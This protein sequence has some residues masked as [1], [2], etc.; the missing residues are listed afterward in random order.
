VQNANAYDKGLSEIARGFIHQASAD[1]VRR[2][3]LTV[4][5]TRSQYLDGVI[6]A[7]LVDPTSW[8]L[9]QHFL[10]LPGRQ[11]A[12][13]ALV[14]DYRSNVDRY[15]Q[16]QGWLREHRPQTLVLWA[17]T[18]R[19]S[20]PGAW[21][22]L[23]D[24]PDARVHLLDTGHFLSKSTCRR[25]RGSSAASWTNEVLHRANVAQAS[26]EFDWT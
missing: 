10:D 2:D 23:R 1:D 19:S 20:L 7:T 16:W 18:I 11:D 9:D 26:R 24:V 14:L 4:A 12:Q 21:A 8:T 5:A 3:L 17:A 13:V 25:S 15:P 6:D 22:Y